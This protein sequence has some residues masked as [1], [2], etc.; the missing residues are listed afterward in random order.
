MRSIA[1]SAFLTAAL[2]SL[3]VPV[4]AQG[5]PEVIDA[6]V[7]EGTERSRVWSYLTTL[8]EG[9]GVRLTGSTSLARA[10]AWARDEYR[11]M[12]LK[13]AH[14]DR[15]GEIPVRFDRG[16]SYVHVE[17]PEHEDLEF[18]TR[19][20]GAG[21]DGPVRGP[22]IVRPGSLEELDALGDRL[23]GA[24]ILSPYEPRRRRSSESDED[25]A[26]AERLVEI[27]AALSTA[28]IAG[29][30]VSS[31]NELLITSSIR[32]WDELTMET[33]PTEVTIQ[34]RKSDH[35]EIA[36][37]VAANEEVIVEAD[38]AHHF[39]EGPFPVFNTVAEIPGKTKPD[40]VIIL[41][42]HLDTWDG[43]GSQGAQDNGT[44][45][46]V[47]L[48]AARILMAV[49]AEPDRTIRFILWTGEEQGL[50]GSRGYVESLSEEERAKIS[51]VLVD[52][53][54]TNYQGGLICIESMAPM[55]DEA[56]G[57]V[58][59]AFPELPMEN[60]VRDRMSRMAGSDHAPFN[61]VGIPGFFW[62]ETGSGGREGKDYN[63]V[64]HTQHD[65]MRYAVDE[66]LVQ[67][68]TCSAIVA[69]QLAQAETLL[70]REDPNAPV[71]E[72]KP[73]PSFV[74]TS[75]ALSGDWDVE[76]LG[77]EAPDM[78]L[79]LTLELAEDG[80]VRGRVAGPMGTD[81]IVE[82]SWKEESATFVVNSDF[83]KLS[84][85]TRLEEG[86]LAG[87]LDVMGSEMPIRG[88]RKAAPAG[89]E[90]VVG[91]AELNGRWEGLITTMDA[92][93][94]L[95]LKVAED[96]S[97]TG[98][99]VSSQSDSELFDGKWDAASNTL[100]F[101]YDYPHAGRLPVVAHFEEGQLVGVIGERA[102]FIAVPYR[103][104]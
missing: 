57:P 15:W 21:T 89:G 72:V 101:E 71:A 104:D 102:E 90:T 94:Q 17:L 98:R 91:A 92:E 34:V 11:S 25:R 1:T 86:Q 51:A 3:P 100:R 60:V 27:E 96:G 75:G 20:W 87:G 4:S 43:P 39:A 12:G 32:G 8:S 2:L 5:D 69:Y 70:P 44:G 62:N 16:L 68:A 78:A 40:E 18:T 28:P 19:S 29:R 41:S 50:F 67:S 74:V 99:Y 36:A 33:L 81:R 76:F 31:S 58:V 82:G 59:A 37:L 93:F 61:Q 38:L 26:A 22:V 13:N 85:T 14:L 83:G 73:D 79:V 45:C 52:D 95:E 103:G 88:T 77:D 64:H 66:Y 24:W 97:V 23:E 47:M 63:F 6:I 53:G 9:I 54:G 35:D 56:I 46:A 80:R 42:G 55:L 7:T 48:E 10:N 65:T 84:W 30:I 49:G